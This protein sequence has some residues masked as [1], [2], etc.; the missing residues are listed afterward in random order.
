MDAFSNVLRRWSRWVEQPAECP[1]SPLVLGVAFV[2]VCIERSDI[3]LHD[4]S[5]G[6]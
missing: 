2:M 4:A 1:L 3:V 5:K 6:M